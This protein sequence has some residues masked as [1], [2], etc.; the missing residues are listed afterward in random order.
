MGIRDASWRSLPLA[1]ILALVKVHW[2]CIKDGVINVDR[3][4]R[5]RPRIEAS[6]SWA[7]HLLFKLEVGIVT[8]LS[9]CLVWSLLDFCHILVDW[10]I[11][12]LSKGT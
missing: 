4:L 3:V 11:R 12:I 1:F 2:S 9:S 8:Q 6:V 10:S 7:C 5:H